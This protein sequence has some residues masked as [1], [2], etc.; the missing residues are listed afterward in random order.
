MSNHSN[1][2]VVFFYRK[3]V[4][5]TYVPPQVPSDDT[6]ESVIEEYLADYRK[7][8]VEYPRLRLDGVYI[9]VCHYV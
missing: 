9:A 3:L 2:G 5:K 7:I 8:Y 6:I 4:E 1:R